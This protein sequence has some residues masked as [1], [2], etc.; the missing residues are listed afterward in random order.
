MS[1]NEVEN[2]GTSAKKVFILKKNFL[3]FAAA[4]VILFIAIISIF[5][6]KNENAISVFYS[7]QQNGAIIV[8]GNKKND[9]YIKGKGVSSVKYSHKKQSAAIVMSEGSSYSLYYTDGKTNVNIASYV[10]NNY[11]IS[12]SGDAVA[13]CN[14]DMQLY[15]YDF[16]KGD[17]KFIDDNVKSFAISS[18]GKTL[19]YIKNEENL[20]N[21]YLYSKG[22]TVYLGE[23]YI[24]LGVS[25]DAK[26]IYVLS[27]DNSLCMLDKSG[28]MIAKI[29]SDVSTD[30]FYF[31]EDMKS[32]VFSDG[33]YTYISIQGKSKNRLIAAP[34]KPFN[35]SEVYCDSSS[36]STIG[37]EL[38][39]NFYYVVNDSGN[40]TVYYIDKELSRTDVSDTVKECTVTGDNSLVYLDSQGKIY[41]FDG[42]SSTLV[43]SGASNMLA[44]SD[45]KYIYCMTVYGEFVCIK[46]DKY[47]VLAN[48]VKKATITNKDIVML[49]RDNGDLYY[50]SGTQMSERID[51]NINNCICYSTAAFYTKNYS[52]QTGVFELYGSDGSARFE[53]LDGNIS[54]IV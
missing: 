11:V 29:C 12:Y 1:E 9:E 2:S 3:I 50:V 17:N 20:Q 4:A 15:L 13:Y 45:G 8:S 35:D 34:T 41:D 43:H 21:L 7:S 47:Y 14:S 42:Q 46:N 39:E 44:S 49:I 37:A 51:E 33:A 53:F 27:N 52:S 31:S 28:N 23:N 32:I 10:T 40:S 16:D 30:G 26:Y 25:D 48:D 18:S 5:G 19:S 24:P 22:T 6:G 38:Y 36:L 54:D